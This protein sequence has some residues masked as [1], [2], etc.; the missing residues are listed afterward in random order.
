MDWIPCR[1]ARQAGTPTASSWPFSR[2][3]KPLDYVAIFAFVSH[4]TDG[5]GR[6]RHIVKFATYTIVCCR[7]HT[8]VEISLSGSGEGL[9]R[10]IAR[11]YSTSGRQL[12]PATFHKS[13][14]G[15]LRLRRSGNRKKRSL[16]S[17]PRSVRAL[18]GPC[19]CTFGPARRSAQGSPASGRHRSSSQRQPRP[20]PSGP[21][22]IASAIPAVTS[23]A[24]SV[25]S[26]A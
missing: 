26:I 19:P 6:L 7:E 22:A 12:G 10:V 23:S 17:P 24:S 14:P 3:C 18:P 8:M 21:N 13:L 5:F 25:D 4:S 20:F 9:G 1:I 16:G 2:H 15:H 11:G